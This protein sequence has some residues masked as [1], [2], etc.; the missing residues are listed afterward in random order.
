MSI[1][2][3]NSRSLHRLIYVSRQSLPAGADVS[4]EV[5]R[6]VEISVRRNSASD[7]TGLLLQHDGWFVQ[8]L[9]GP[10]EAVMTTYQRILNDQRHKN[11]KVISAGPAEHREFGA[12]SMCARQLGA[13]DGAIIETL[14]HKG[15]FEPS[16]LAPAS[17][18]RLLQA[19]R[20]IKDRAAA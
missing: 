4:A 16:K 7:I 1:E 11:S 13:T 3:S 9:E 8:A 20:Q 2:V 18:L 12:W 15:P 14:K 19:V 17:A 10:M 5:S 6:I